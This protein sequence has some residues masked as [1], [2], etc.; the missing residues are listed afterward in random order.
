M[1][2]HRIRTG[3]QRSPF[4][5]ATIMIDNCHDKVWRLCVL[6]GLL[7]RVVERVKPAVRRLSGHLPGQLCIMTGQGPEDAGHLS[8]VEEYRP[9]VLPGLIGDDRE[10]ESEIGAERRKDSCCYVGR[11]RIRGVN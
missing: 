11:A 3:K 10:V 5:N 8:G 1:L 9:G 7:R 2:R 4:C 6:I